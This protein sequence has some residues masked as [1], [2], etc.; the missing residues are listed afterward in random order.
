MGIHRYK[1][2]N[3]DDEDS[4]F[5]PNCEQCKALSESLTRLL[6]SN[7]QNGTSCS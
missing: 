6:D 4:R 3:K 7:R 5:V 1:D 2:R